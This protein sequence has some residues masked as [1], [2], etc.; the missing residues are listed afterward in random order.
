MDEPIVRRKRRYVVNVA[1]QQ[2]KVPPKPPAAAKL[3]KAAKPKHKPKKKKPA[4]PAEPQ[5]SSEELKELRIKRKHNKSIKRIKTSF[6]FLR[7]AFPAC[8][9]EPPVPLSVGTREVIAKLIEK[10]V[11]KEE[12]RKK[13]IN[14]ICHWCTRYDYIESVAKGGYRYSI[15]GQAEPIEPDH[16]ERGKRMLETRLSVANDKRPMVDQI[17]LGIV[18]PYQI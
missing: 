7:K 6:D 2:K 13:I 11:K 1:P 15:H 4:K 14:T 10:Y 8:F 5:L 17:L 12:K 18:V 3:K 9:T 16:A